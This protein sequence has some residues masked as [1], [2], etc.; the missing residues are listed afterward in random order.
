MLV[1]A[2]HA[3]R[4]HDGVATAHRVQ[5]VV[6]QQAGTLAVLDLA[7]WS[8]RCV[9]SQRKLA[10]LGPTACRNTGRPPVRQDYGRNIHIRPQLFAKRSALR[11][12]RLSS[13]RLTRKIPLRVS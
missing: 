4:Q 5:F 2:N 9:K 3:A 10:S 1:A 13:E 8:A 7:Y 6:P 12:D 11:E